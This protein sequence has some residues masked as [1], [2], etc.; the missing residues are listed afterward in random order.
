[1]KN[2]KFLIFIFLLAIACEKE[3]EKPKEEA[4]FRTID[5]YLY[6]ADSEYNKEELMYKQV[7]FY[8]TD[9]NIEEIHF[10]NENH[11]YED[12][13]VYEYENGAMIGMTVYDENENQD[14]YNYEIINN[15][16]GQIIE[17]IIYLNNDISDKSVYSYYPDGNIKAESLYSCY[18]GECN[19][20][21]TINYEYN[22]KG[23]LIKEYI[24]DSSITTY[25]YP[26]YDKNGNWIVRYRHKSDVTGDSYT[27]TEREIEYY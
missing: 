27:V 14:D 15:E 19:L 22:E 10:Y 9:G 24:G 21:Y 6:S 8:D 25:S 13:T 2:T 23:N 3:E 4:Q 1:M 5:E 20:S 16:D 17:W 7:Y 26:D 18:N 12:K 11:V